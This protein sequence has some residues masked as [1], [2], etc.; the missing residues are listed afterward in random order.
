ML[1]WI[2]DKS[3]LNSNSYKIILTYIYTP[4]SFREHPPKSL[5]QFKQPWPNVKTLHVYLW[6]KT[7]GDFLLGLEPKA[8]WHSCKTPST[9]CDHVITPSAGLMNEESTWELGFTQFQLTESFPRGQASDLSSH[10][11]T[12]VHSDF[13]GYGRSINGLKYTILNSICIGSSACDSAIILSFELTG[14]A[15]FQNGGVGNWKVLRESV[16]LPW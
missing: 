11:E 14:P 8:Q 12:Q 9:E 13:N 6:S 15:Y 3:S 7:P 16:L 10:K 5:V 4:C 1:R 2:P